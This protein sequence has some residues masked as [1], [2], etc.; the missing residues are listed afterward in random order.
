MYG[1]HRDV[2]SLAAAA[3]ATL[4]EECESVAR[5]L[6][7][8]EGRFPATV[9]FVSRPLFP[10]TKHQTLQVCPFLQGY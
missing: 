5:R 7:E 10:S 4:Q 1:Q 3:S 2:F 8:A 9:D 6:H